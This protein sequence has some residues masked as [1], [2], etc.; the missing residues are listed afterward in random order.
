MAYKGGSG[1]YKKGGITVKTVLVDQV[2]NNS[3]TMVNAVSLQFKPLA[4]KRYYGWLILRISSAT[5]AD[6]D[7]NFTALGGTDYGVYWVGDSLTP[8]NPTALGTFL[9]LVTDG[10]VETLRLNFM[11]GGQNAGTTLNF[12]YAQ[13][14]AQSSDTKILTGTMMVIF[15]E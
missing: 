15:Q 3:E 4:E 5:N 2:V 14:T 12:K 10:S 7:I 9:P 1:N 11:F 6:M 13:G 8:E